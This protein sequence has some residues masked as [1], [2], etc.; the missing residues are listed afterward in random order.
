MGISHQHKG[1]PKKSLQVHLKMERCR[2]EQII[3]IQRMLVE[4]VGIKA[5]CVFKAF[6]EYGSPRFQLSKTG[7]W[8]IA[9]RKQRGGIPSLEVYVILKSSRRLTMKRS[10]FWLQA[11]RQLWSLFNN[12][13]GAR[14]P[15]LSD[16]SE[17]ALLCFPSSTKSIF[18][19]KAKTRKYL[20][21]IHDG[22][23]F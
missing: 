8:Q 15:S 3:L 7:L 5:Y 20:E 22:N 18:T 11:T 9:A 6:C 4:V 10:P 1:I 21:R 17:F 13:I 14:P 16:W 19:A 2:L 23:K 12:P